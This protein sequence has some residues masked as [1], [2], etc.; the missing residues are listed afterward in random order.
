MATITHHD[1]TQR[2]Q[3]DHLKPINSHNHLLIFFVLKLVLRYHGWVE[4]NGYWDP[5]PIG[6]AQPGSYAVHSPP[7]SAKVKNE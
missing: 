2:V 1:V 7:Y 6:K 3:S 5:F 4:F